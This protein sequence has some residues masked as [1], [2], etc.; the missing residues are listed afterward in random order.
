[1][2]RPAVKQLHNLRACLYLV[3]HVCDEC[4]GEVLQQGMQQRGVVEHDHLRQEM[5]NR[6]R[7]SAAK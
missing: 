1:V 4:C 5:Q 6:N 2:V 7:G 3:A